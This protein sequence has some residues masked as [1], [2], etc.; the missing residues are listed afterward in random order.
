[1]VRGN[2]NARAEINGNI[3]STGGV[4]GGLTAG[5]GGGGSTV[6]ITPVLEVGEKIA[7]F[8]IDDVPGELFAP[9]P[10]RYSLVKHVLYSNVNGAP[11]FTP[12]E[13]THN[14]DDY[15]IIYMKISNPRDISA[16]N[17]YTHHSFMPIMYAPGERISI[18]ALYGQRVVD[19]VFSGNTCEI[20]RTDGDYNDNTIYEII[21]IRLGAV[22]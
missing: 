1:M 8:V 12:L 2:I 19:I 16:F 11:R 13:L 15:D 9:S 17:L 20:V 5:T 7:D 21:G 10:I 22:V 6:S 14:F 4:S 3:N 18:Q